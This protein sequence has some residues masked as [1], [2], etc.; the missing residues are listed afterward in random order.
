MD[1]LLVIDKPSGPTSHDVVARMRRVLK[2]RGIGHTGTLDPMATGVLALVLGRATRLAKFM[3]ASDKSYDAWVSLGV[4]TDT[5][6]ADGAAIGARYRGPLPAAATIDA[7]LNAFRG[8]FLQR[9][10]AYSA[11]K[12]AG[13]RSYALARAERA[14]HAGRMPSQVPEP[15]SVTAHAI[16]IT[17]L[18][19]DRLTLSVHCSS[20]FYI[21]SLADDLGERL[22]T[23]AHLS[24]LRRTRS[25]EFSLAAAIA[26]DVAEQNPDEAAAFV[27]P[28]GQLLT[29]FPAVVLS[30][31]G[32]LR[33][34]HG[35]DLGPGD[36]IGAGAR[37]N[38][39]CRLVDREGGLVAIGE[40]AR[41]PGLLHPSIVLV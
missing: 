10:P 37:P 8:T 24:A 9:P 33:A 32:V 19:D 2:E 23:G 6:D 31:E 20:G 5:A 15:V 18:E 30:S 13:T 16:E 26:L 28:M 34:T 38:P 36:V 7:A 11:K 17:S 35:R 29:G 22:G 12:I 27:I 14:D 1:G 3:S 40:P 39:F 4:R 41:T 21:R 25:G